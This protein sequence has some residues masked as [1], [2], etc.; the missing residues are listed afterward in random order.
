[1]SKPVAVKPK[2]VAKKPTAAKPN[3]VVKKPTAAKPKPVVKKAIK[4]Y[5]FGITKG[6]V[7]DI[8]MAF[9]QYKKKLLGNNNEY[10]DNISGYITD[11][12]NLQ[13]LINNKLK[14]LGDKQL[15]LLSINYYLPNREGKIDYLNTYIKIKKGMETILH[16]TNITDTKM[17]RVIDKNEAC[18]IIS[19]IERHY[20][21]INNILEKFDI[22]I[23]NIN[24]GKY[25]S[26][27]S[28]LPPE[29]DLAQLTFSINSFKKNNTDYLEDETLLNEL[30]TYDDIEKCITKIIQKYINIGDANIVELINNYKFKYY[31]L[32]S[33]YKL[34]TLKKTHTFTK[35]HI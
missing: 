24:K 18:S 21:D 22:Y 33:K 5:G 2:A 3:Q 23:N 10:I 29:Y 7:E 28:T 11:V 34:R 14:E 19:N 35:R 30:S 17:E 20:N 26:R 15:I 27:D 32:I 4:Q 12:S 6:E 8:S 16:Y 25:I 1:M 31:E 13:S 9:E